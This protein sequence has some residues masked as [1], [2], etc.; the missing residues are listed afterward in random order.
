LVS[1]EAEPYA[2][3]ATAFEEAFVQERKTDSLVKLQPGEPL[4]SADVVV[5]LGSSSADQLLDAE[6]PLVHCMTLGAP[7]GEAALVLEHPMEEQLKLIQ[8]VLPRSTRLGVVYSNEHSARIVER[9]RGL[10]AAHGLEL[11]EV[12]IDSPAGLTKALKGLANRIDALWGVPDT[13]LYNPA[14]SKAVLLF[15]FRHQVP[16]IGLS[17]EWVKA[18][19]TMGPS[20][21]YEAIGRQC[22]R[23]AGELL[24]GTPANE[25]GS[26]APSVMPYTLNRHSIEQLNLSVASSVLDE[27]Q[28]VY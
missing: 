1:S 18:G 5:A 22:A 10:V 21:D 23:M 27:A 16:F 17:E 3:V 25:I 8:K 9:A 2:A 4:A 28:H 13:S 14:T 19:A 11:V 20:F 7:D 6:S 15:S 12:R 24:D 26:R